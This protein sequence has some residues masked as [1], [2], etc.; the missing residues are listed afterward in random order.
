[1]SRSLRI[2][3]ALFVEAVALWSPALPD[4][5]VARAAFRGEGPS[6]AVPAKRPAPEL[7][8]PAERRRAPDTVALALETAQR[9]VAQSGL[10][11]DELLSVFTSCHG[12]LA[13]TDY[14]CST[15]VNSPTAVSP[16]RFHNS[17][18]NAASG[19]WG[20][21][22]ACMQA[23]TAVSAFEHSFAAG[24]LE[25]LTQAA[26]AVRPVLLVGYD[27]AAVG[28]LRSTT[29]SRGQLAMALVVA[30]SRSERTLATLGWSLVGGPMPRIDLRSEA[31]RSLVDNAMADGLPLFEALAR[32]HDTPLQMP[33]SSS[34][35][36][37]IELSELA[38]VASDRT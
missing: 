4:W 33:L 1:M 17:V 9:A 12:D 34:C 24:L 3:P 18:H 14:M 10:R 38:A 27:I 6:A 7:L 29:T 37:R 13:V 22:T 25:A 16:T 20:I 35:A 21:A 32:E 8:P 5:R 19:Y 11:A 23:S 28:A 31:A 15:L 26:A 36:L 30:P 2:E